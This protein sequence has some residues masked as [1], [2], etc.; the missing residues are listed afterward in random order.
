M[1]PLR[2]SETDRPYT[3]ECEV[4]HRICLPWSRH[5]DLYRS[6]YAYV[7]SAMSLGA[8]RYNRKQTGCS[9]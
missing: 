7:S 5:T 8:V 3:I 6:E 9:H 4:P 2:R 1:S